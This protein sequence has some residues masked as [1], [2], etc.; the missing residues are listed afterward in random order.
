[1][2][3][4]GLT[5]ANPFALFP[6][7][8]MS[9]W[10]LAN[11][12]VS[13]PAPDLLNWPV[14]ASDLLTP[15][16]ILAGPNEFFLDKSLSVNSPLK[17]VN[18]G[19][20]RTL[21]GSGN[22]LL[23]PAWGQAFT[24]QVRLFAPSYLD[25]VGLPRGSFFEIASPR[26]VSN[27]L[28]A[29]QASTPKAEHSVLLMAWGQ[30]VDHDL[31]LSAE[32]HDFWPIMVPT[33]DSY[34]DPT[35]TGQEIIPFARLAYANGTGENGVARASV[36]TI[37][38]YLDASMVYGSSL[39]Q[40]RTLRTLD[41]TGRLRWSTDTND[42]VMLPVHP[43]LTTVAG[44]AR[45]HENPILSSLHSLFVAEHNRV[46]DLLW[47]EYNGRNRTVRSLLRHTRWRNEDVTTRGD[48]VYELA[49]KVVGAQVQA[50]TYGEFLPELIG[51]DTLSDYTGYKTY[52]N[53]AISEEFSNA[54]YRLG[55][56]MV[57][58]QIG[59][60]TDNET[61][62]YEPL[63]SN[64]F[65]PEM[66]T[67][68]GKAAILGGAIAMEMNPVDLEI[69]G[70]LRNMLFG[71]NL[72][73]AAINI[74]RG[75]DA[76]LPT[77]AAAHEALGYGVVDE[78]SDITGVPATQQALAG[79]YVTPGEVDLWVG[80]LAEDKVADSL[81]GE[82]GTAILADQFTRTR[83]G[84]RFYYENDP[85]VARLDSVLGLSLDT[86]RLEDV[87]EANTS[88]SVEDAFLAGSVEF[89]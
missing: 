81:L 60:L 1:M 3:Q 31:V 41:G 67:Q 82:V 48:A 47:E 10:S 78:F 85:V 35:G 45:A 8:W 36:N 19:Q 87:I 20:V 17:R 5:F 34:F 62:E 52:V 56:S 64:F 73:L 68:E 15:Q 79:V 80:I 66:L 72:D 16:T 37:T 14:S 57:R 23:R 24:E 22:N 32:S 83:D 46:V 25:G 29:S 9:N 30:F 75:R 18:W 74:Q 44:D 55:H 58:D 27:A 6:V 86:L 12:S 53:P 13:R 7:A 61:L 38:P 54:A 65:N 70:A 71:A 4:L 84:D 49:R 33:G 42:E 28:M 76:G 77:F 50:I 40:S 43:D 88:L 11:W 2:V 21:D 39:E 63:M 51:A 59:V 26:V 69:T 89:V